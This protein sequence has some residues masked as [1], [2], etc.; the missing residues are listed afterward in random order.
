M[1]L[2]KWVDTAVVRRSTAH[3]SHRA[4]RREQIVVAAAGAIEEYGAGVGTAQIAERAGVARPHVYRHFNSKD[5]LE[6]E[7][8][9]FAATQ[10]IE[11]VRPAM[12]HSGT[13][14]VIIEGVIEAAVR[15]AAEHPNLYRFM[16]ARQ[17]T[18]A[19]HRARLGRTRFL[20]EVVAATSAYLRTPDIQVDPPDG[21]MAGLMGMVDAGIIWWLD[22]HDE[23]QD[24]VV[25]RIAHQV[26]LVMRDLAQSV[27]LAIDNESL[28]TVQ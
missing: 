24:E 6:S 8:L 11:T 15:W 1:D 3:D 20:G 12:R 26:W 14:P 18:K 5:D 27:G 25:T 13:A 23:S 28:L 17:Q 16:A 4:P 10:L 2:S 7:V 9:R 22:H 21:V 19:T